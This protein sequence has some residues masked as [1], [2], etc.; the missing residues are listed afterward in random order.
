[1]TTTPL[2]WIKKLET[3]LSETQEIPLW[4]YPP[5]F[6]WEE[7]ISPLEQALAIK[8]LALAPLRTDWKPSEELLSG[9]G[10]NPI[11]VPIELTPL[12]G[13]IYWIMPSEDVSR[14]TSHVL[15][16]NHHKGF[17]DSGLQQGF[18]HY[19]LLETL[20]ALDRSHSF[21]ELSAQLSEATALPNEGAM[22]I[23]IGISFEK[24]KV[25]GRLICSSE[26]QQSYKTHFSMKK[27]SLQSNEIAKQMEVILR[28]EI[29]H[30][31][32]PLAQWQQIVKGDLLLLDRCSYDPKT[33]KGTLGIVLDNTPLFRARFKESTIKILD[34]AFYCEASMDS[35]ISD[36]PENEENIYGEDPLKDEIENGA[37]EGPLWSASE[38][39]DLSL[40]KVISSH[41][42]PM[43]VTVEIG[44]LRMNLEKLLQLKPG[45]TLDLAVHPEQSVALTING[46]CVAR[47]ELIKLGEIL[48]VKILQIGD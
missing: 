31:T 36:E 30:T 48:G 1:M 4:G 34:Y 13:K 46:K 40:E 6:P 9:M 28:L 11:I 20:H 33:C 2:S 15:N 37:E 39:Q 26:F 18:Y 21:P 47:G 35:P 5:P 7:I 17:A 10:K 45:N 3:T 24:G 12:A 27:I 43:T 44:K 38:T 19:L 25:W 23:D 41:E 29:G 16:P 22:C 8:N 32:L 42:I 14:L